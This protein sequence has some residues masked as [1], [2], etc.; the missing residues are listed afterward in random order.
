[1][2][3]RYVSTGTANLKHALHD[4]LL[5]IKGRPRQP[6]LAIVANADIAF[7]VTRPSGIERASG[8]RGR[9]L[10]FSGTLVER[11]FC[12]KTC[13]DRSAFAKIDSALLLFNRPSIQYCVRPHPISE[14]L[15]AHMP[16]RPLGGHPRAA[17][18]SGRAGHGC[19]SLRARR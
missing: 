14:S 1:M 16:P 8:H 18:R 10:R 6:V 13:L 19:R 17:H 9:P 4:A 5:E 3:A 15:H 11:I 7:K 2:L 12:A